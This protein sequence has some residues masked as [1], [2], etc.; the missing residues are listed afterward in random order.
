LLDLTG[1]AHIFYE[2]MEMGAPLRLIFA[3]LDGSTEV[4]SSAGLSISKVVPYHNLTLTAKDFVF[5]PGLDYA[6]LSRADFLKENTPFLNW[7]YK[8]YENGASIASV[9]T[10]A[11][12]LAEAGILNGKKCTTHW[13][14]LTR[15]RERYPRAELL[16]N[17]LF[18]VEDRLYT[19]AGVSSGID[20]SL[21][22]LEKEFSLKLA[23]NVA[24]ETVIY[25]RRSEYDPQLS[26]Y[27]QYRNHLEERIHQVQEVLVN[28][29]AH[30]LTLEELAEQVFMSP[31][32]LTR[33]FKKSTGITIGKYQNKLRL[34][35]ATFLLKEGQKVEAVAQAC[36]FSGANQL[37]ELL[38][39]ETGVLP[40][41]L[42]PV[43]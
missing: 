20:L 42:F 6:L 38:K 25:F 15:F 36:G 11:F 12:L 28:N 32:N 19:S 34:E 24:K 13:K 9:C 29:L 39:K 16:E 33:L 27:L 23:V 4:E 17:R 3:S 21:F 30:G 8:Q 14:Y 10:G 35:Q 18:V 37:R 5:V 41:S 7:L 43:K 2:A 40:A 26:I 1:P 31:R 22:I